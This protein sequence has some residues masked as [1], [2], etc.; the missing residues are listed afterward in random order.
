[1]T[2]NN[3]INFVRCGFLSA[4]GLVFFAVL[5]VVVGQQSFADTVRLPGLL[6]SITVI[7]NT[8]SLTLRSNKL[9]ADVGG[10]DMEAKPGTTVHTVVTATQEST[11]AIAIGMDEQVAKKTAPTETS[12]FVSINLVKGSPAFAPGKV[13]L[14]YSSIF[15]ERGVVLRNWTLCGTL[16]LELPQ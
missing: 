11:G 5:A 12:L 4:K 6:R 13:T 8:S 16:E 14:C 1:M 3:L 10:V 9:V 15:R 7:S 2:T